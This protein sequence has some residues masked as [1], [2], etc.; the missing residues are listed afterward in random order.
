MATHVAAE[1]KSAGDFTVAP[2]VVPAV[3]SAVVAV[4]GMGV[5]TWPI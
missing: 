2:A 5:V 3:V 4:M 1:V